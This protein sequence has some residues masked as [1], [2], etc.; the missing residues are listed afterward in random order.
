MTLSERISSGQARTSSDRQWS[1]QRWLVAMFVGGLLTI[2]SAVFNPVTPVADAAASGSQASVFKP[3]ARINWKPCN[4][5]FECARVK[6]PLNWARPHGREIH[7]GVIRLRAEKPQKRI[8]SLFLNPGGPGGSGVDFVR[9]LKGAGGMFGHGRFDLVSW[10]VRGSAGRST[11]VNCFA[12]QPSRIRFWG[13]STLPTTVPA[14][15]AYRK[16]TAAFARRCGQRNPALMRHISSA[17]HARDLDHLRRL[18]GDRRLNFYGF[19]YGSFLGQTYAN[20]F[21]GRVRA[22]ALDSIVDPVANTRGTEA[23]AA[24]TTQGSDAVLRQFARLCEQ[25]GPERCALAG[26]SPVLPR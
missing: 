21:P 11:S 25:A 14:S 4:N 10:D 19:S 18:V 7:L 6:V 3:N 1:R 20:M 2:L 24:N 5:G 13:T 22:M 8:G 12:D 16:K 9:Q 26:K 23:V 17:D 15:R